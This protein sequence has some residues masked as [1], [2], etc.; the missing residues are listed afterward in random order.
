MKRIFYHGTTLENAR[1]IITNGFSFDKTN[2]IVSENGVYF[3]DGERL[4]EDGNPVDRAYENAIFALAR[5]GTKC[6]I[7]GVEIDDELVSDDFSCENMDGAVVCFETG[8]HK[9]IKEIWVSPDLSLF[10]VFFIKMALGMDLCNNDFSEM[11]ET[12]AKHVS[13]DFFFDASDFPLELKDS[14]D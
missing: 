13:N 7:L 8:L 5:G 14:L 9:N 6:A 10:R 12:A 11:E 1:E 2:W 4:D 3:W